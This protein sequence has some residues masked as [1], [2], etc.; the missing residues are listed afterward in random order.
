VEIAP[1]FELLFCSKGLTVPPLL[2]VQEILSIFQSLRRW[3]NRE[4]G[5]FVL[6]SIATQ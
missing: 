3:G 2:P 6:C 5:R 1:L 4:W